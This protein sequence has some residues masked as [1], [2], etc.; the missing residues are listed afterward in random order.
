MPSFSTTS[1]NHAHFFKGE[2]LGD[3]IDNG[4][5]TGACLTLFPHQ[6]FIIVTSKM[7]GFDPESLILG[8][9]QSIHSRDG[10]KFQVSYQ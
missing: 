9:E 2:A 1:G 7:S 6:V 5:L 10:K 8:I 3:G 4:S